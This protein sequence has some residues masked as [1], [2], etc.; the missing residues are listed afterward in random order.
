MKG[1]PSSLKKRF[2]LGSHDKARAMELALKITGG[3][4]C[5]ETAQIG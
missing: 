3:R 4:L 1:I 2:T 5:F